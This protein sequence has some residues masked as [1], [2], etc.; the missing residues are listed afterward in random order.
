MPERWGVRWRVLGVAVTILAVTLAVWT[1]LLLALFESTFVGAARQHA[2]V[3]VQQVAAA[4]SQVDP[5]RAVPVQDGDGGGDVVVQVL[6]GEG[7]VVAAST[8]EALSQ[9]VTGLAPAVGRTE[10]RE[11]D[12]LPGIDEDGFVVAARGAVGDDGQRLTV[13]VASP[14]H[15]EEGVQARVFGWGALAAVA[16]LAVAAVLVRWAVGASLRPVERLRGQLAVID[17][18]TIGDRVDVPGTGDELTRLAETMNQMLAR[19][20]GAYAAQSGFVSDASHE[21]RSPLATL[22]TSV[23]LAAADPTGEVWRET[24]PVVTAELLRLQRLVDDL[25]TLS[26]YDAGAVPLRR[27]ECDLDDLVVG[28]AR[29]AA[30]ETGHHV[31]VA[32]EPVRVLADPDR[33]GQVLRN[34]LDNA[35]R[36]AAGRVRVGVA[37]AG[38]DAVVTVDNDGP[39]VPESERERIFERFVR[40]DETRDRDTGGAGLGLAIAADIAH[41]HDGALRA[42]A[43]GDGWCRFELRLPLEALDPPERAGSPR[44]ARS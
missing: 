20:E 19:L 11:V 42:G 44:R 32:A 3:Q 9:P 12:R 5:E 17:G 15:I 24:Q 1:W 29:T 23:E 35:V 40:L 14:V 7:G 18:H 43:A 31:D 25:L 10:V 33:L 6:D 21:L 22:R 4:V 26:K 37:A 39:P 8:R 38:E 36:H 27:R 2:T 30:A 13:V 34:L 28:A 41:A 16:V